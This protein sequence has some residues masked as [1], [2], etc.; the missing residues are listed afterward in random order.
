MK[1]FRILQLSGARS[2]YNNPI[3]HAV[4]K[5]MTYGKS[6]PLKTC[7]MPSTKAFINRFSNAGCLFKPS[8]GNFNSKSAKDRFDNFSAQHEKAIEEASNTSKVLIN[9]LNASK[10]SKDH[11]QI[12][13]HIDSLVK[14][15]ILLSEPS[16]LYEELSLALKKN[17][18]HLKFSNDSDYNSLLVLLDKITSQRP[19]EIFQEVSKVYYRNIS[20]FSTE[21]LAN[22]IF[23][24]S[25]YSI[26]DKNTWEKL[27]QQFTSQ[28]AEM[29]LNQL[30]KCFMAF[31]LVND[32]L[33]ALSRSKQSGISFDQR[34]FIELLEKIASK[35][36]EMNYLDTF[37]I[38]IAL[39]K[40]SVEYGNVPIKLWEVI[41]RNFVTNISKFDMYQSSQILLILCEGSYVDKHTFSKIEK[42][43]LE[44]YIEKIP[45]VIEKQHLEFNY[46]SL[47]E[48]IA[49][50]GFCFIVNKAGS[51]YFWMRFLEVI[52][53][54]KAHL[55]IGTIENVLF[56]CYRLIDY[57]NAFSMNDSTKQ[58]KHSA[59]IMEIL[60]LIEKKL[61]EDQ[62]LEKNSI[63]PFSI[64]LAF[65]RVSK[66]NE[67]IWNPMTKNVL[68][69]LADKDFFP[70]PHLLCDITYAFS[71]YNA[72]LD[73]KANN[74]YS[75]NKE[76]FW[77]TIDQL[78]NKRLRP[79]YLDI[80]H[81][82]NL[83]LDMTN[84]QIE[85]PNVERVIEGEFLRGRFEEMDNVSFVLILLGYS[86][87]GFPN[88]AVTQKLEEYFIKNAKDM[89]VSDIKK[90]VLCFIR[91]KS[92]SR[93]LWQE[94]EKQLERRTEEF[95]LQLVS[96]LQ[97]PLALVGIHSQSIW[98]RF[99][100][101]TLRNFNDLRED[102]E[103][104]MNAIFAFTK[105]T[106]G[107]KV[108]WKKMFSLLDS[109]IGGFNI[110]D[111]SHVV[112]CLD[113]K[114]FKD[115]AE[116]YKELFEENKEFWNKLVRLIRE[117]LPEAKIS[118]LN[119]L[120]KSFSENDMLKTHIDAANEIEQKLKAKLKDLK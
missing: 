85:L 52:H 95:D 75:N 40:K 55:Q 5:I 91:A 6:N 78:F 96:D 118:T 44:S 12:F 69:I 4:T 31:A 79:E 70:F 1:I 89:T 11:T 61:L 119:S 107:S 92:A 2:I 49:R 104:Y 71:S 33:D 100:E 15:P 65:A 88:A 86:S 42:E 37:R 106:M 99:E 64:M 34:F 3:K 26:E 62:L 63:D 113:P 39:S 102:H 114:H 25:K 57:L 46:A 97:I 77:G 38:S 58:S 76:K 105:V 94:V 14:L 109:N 9:S 35:S 98:R 115:K 116:I 30:I 41:Q 93:D 20:N 16:E 18:G 56:I 110:D 66:F 117:R 103:Y 13:N 7:F 60:D 74:F 54:L 68:E 59:Q 36:D 19:V 101:M 90:I 50:L 22:L 48:D 67:S 21:T 24:S 51:E 72:F 81:I 53:R 84:I 80:G 23:S 87:R 73:E 111:L 27:K 17:A 45:N 120:V 83:F 29:N 82:A 108:Y 28:K 32:S 10:S 8:R 112:L 43:I 47:L